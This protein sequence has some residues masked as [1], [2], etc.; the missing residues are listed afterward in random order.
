MG[1]EAQ[2]ADPRFVA[3][4]EAVE[5]AALAAGVPLAGAALDGARAAELT[6]RGYRALLRGIDLFIL[7]AAVAAFRA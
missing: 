1:I 5:R 4:V 6:A 3:A 2:F 7:Q